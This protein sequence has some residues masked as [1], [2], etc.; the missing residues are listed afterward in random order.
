MPADSSDLYNGWVM[1]C[2]QS[3]HYLLIIFLGFGFGSGLAL[4]GDVSPV[5]DFLAVY[6]SSVQTGACRLCEHPP[7]REVARSGEKSHK[8]DIE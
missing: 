7:R 4:V 1:K 8:D 6:N 2:A 5:L 3:Y